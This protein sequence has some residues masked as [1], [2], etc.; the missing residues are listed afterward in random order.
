MTILSDLSDKLTK[1]K[2]DIRDVGLREGLQSHDM[3]VPTE[4][5]ARL[6]RGLA[7]A[8]I[9]EINAVSF[10]SAKKMPHMADAEAL[11]RS[12][13]ETRV[14][15]DV[16]GVVFSE[17]GLERALKLHD[18]GLLDTVFLVFSPEVTTLAA[19]GFTADPEALLQQ[20][21]RCALQAGEHGLKV[22]VFLSESF[23]SPI[24]GWMD[25][26]RVLAH[27]ERIHN[28]RGVTELIISDSTGQADPIQVLALFTD[29]ADILPIERRITFH[30]HDSRGAGLA[31][32][33]AAL[34]SP[35]EHFCI[36]SSFGGLGGDYPFI[37]DAFGNVATEDLVE[38]LHGMGVETGVDPD[39]V[40]AVSRD[41]AAVSGRP[42]GSRLSGCSAALTWKREHRLINPVREP[43]P[44]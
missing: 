8:G 11:L 15:I 27:A 33:W 41:Y 39:S 25:P 6:F 38:M 16:S 31:N 22:G 37:P 28:M 23:G 3:I 43:T 1:T 21:E 5:K 9:R 42:L 10:V 13:G 34:N 24:S 26:R 36:D 17:G 7:E 12:L 29:L 19:N 2:V 18:E 44:V 30:V 35:F 20:I 32:V 40:V 4:T 14:G